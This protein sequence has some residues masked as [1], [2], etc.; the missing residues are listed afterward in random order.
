MQHPGKLKQKEATSVDTENVKE[1]EEVNYDLPQMSLRTI[2]DATDKFSESNK[3]GEGGYGPVYK[4]KLPNGQEIAVKR[5]S[6]RSGQGLKEFKNEVELIV[7][8]QHVNLVRLIACS[9]EKGEKMLIYEY[10]PNKSLDF[11]LKDPESRVL[12]DWE[13][14]FNIIIGIARGILYLH[15][16]SR[17]NVI[18]RD[19]KASN[20]LLD[21]QLNPKI[22]DFGLARI[23]S[24][25]Q[26]QATTSI[27][28]GTY[29]YMAPEYA[30]DGVFSTKS[31]VYSFGILL[32]EMISGQLNSAFISAT[33]QGRGLVE[34]A[35]SLWS[36]EKG[37]EFIDP[38]LKDAATSTSNQMLRCLHI[39]FLC[40]QED[41]ATRPTM[42]T[43]VLM[44]GNDS[45]DLPLPKQPASF[46]ENVA[47][48]S[49]RC[50]SV[51]TSVASEI[52]TR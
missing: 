16:D 14:R 36:E 21:E 20:V 31:D 19:L 28:V 35:W 2:E 22:S 25:V 5:L 32:F 46:G 18:H 34:Q 9:L 45:V 44:L 4:G 6:G 41:P 49:Q 1:N 40:I 43:V 8:L 29:G 24:G 12:L 27:V 33:L 7:K 39:G 15:Q 11:F 37:T 23:F 42:S 26:G 13:K 38:V 50:S 3:L 48:S 52:T 30:M 10:M 47:D 17:L 51:I